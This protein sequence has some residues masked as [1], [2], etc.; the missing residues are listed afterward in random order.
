M[1]KLVIGIFA[2]LITAFVLQGCKSNS[3][4]TAATP[5]PTVQQTLDGVPQSEA[6][7]KIK[8]FS[9]FSGKDVSSKSIAVFYPIAQ[10]KAID[11]ILTKEHT[12]TTATGIRFH[13]GCDSPASGNRNLKIYMVATNDRKVTDPHLST[14]VDYYVHVPNILSTTEIGTTNY[15]GSD[16]YKKGGTLYGTMPPAYQ[17]C[18]NPSRHFLPANTAYQWVQVRYDKGSNDQTP[19]NTTSEWFSYCF[20]H[21]IIKTM[22]QNKYTG[23]RVYL[24]KGF[25]DDSCKNRD[26][27]I[28]VPTKDSLGIMH[29]DD[30]HC[31]EDLPGY[32]ICPDAISKLHLDKC[33]T[34]ITSGKKHPPITGGGGY[35]E[36][37]L[38]PDVCD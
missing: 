38:C 21:S 18:S 10:L 36:G 26:V 34:I 7:Q 4:K 31:L 14:H 29:Q 37:E 9:D 22:A 32:I 8:N 30:Y 35:D 12:D 2:V 6:L 28:L 15:N 24:G 11:S 25:V 13:F 17:S 23:L 1:K 3:S 20:M 16:E 27:V 5:P 19:L 33:T